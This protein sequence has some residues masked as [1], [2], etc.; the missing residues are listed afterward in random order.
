MRAPVTRLAGVQLSRPAICSHCGLAVREVTPE[1]CLPLLEATLSHTVTIGLGCIYISSPVR[2][3]AVDIPY[4]LFNNGL[5]CQDN[6]AILRHAVNTDRCR[7]FTMLPMDK[8]QTASFEP[9]F[10][11]NPSH[12]SLVACGFPRRKTK[13]RSRHTLAYSPSCDSDQ[14]SNSLTKLCQDTRVPAYPTTCEFEMS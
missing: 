4:C 12:L 7:H 1:W 9:M 10:G 3:N 6:T 5:M 13:I 14:R 11:T 2:F 8:S